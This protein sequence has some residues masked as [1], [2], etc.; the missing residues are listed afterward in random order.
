M[1]DE[2]YKK[3]SIVQQSCVDV[4]IAGDDADEDSKKM[5]RWVSKVWW[6]QSNIRSKDEVKRLCRG[7][8]DGKAATAWDQKNKRWGT[9]LIEN[10]P[11]LIASGL[12]TPDGIDPSLADTIAMRISTQL[13]R[14]SEQKTSNEKTGK[15]KMAALPQGK[16]KQ[17]QPPPPQP[18]SAETAESTK[19][20]KFDTPES[21]LA[22][23]AEINEVFEAYGMDEET[24]RQTARWAWLGSSCTRS[25]VRVRRWFNFSRNKERGVSTV[26]KEDFSAF[27]QTARDEQTKAVDDA[28]VRKAFDSNAA[29]TT[30]TTTTISDMEKYQILKSREMALIKS[31]NV[32][33]DAL[34][35]ENEHGAHALALNEI[36]SKGAATPIAKH[37]ILFKCPFCN[38]RPFEQF[39]QCACADNASANWKRC[40]VC[41]VI[42]HPKKIPCH[43]N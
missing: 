7:T 43:C 5:R 42:C 25:I 35:W 21:F 3:L 27:A 17:P 1:S 41:N 36:T 15:M 14:E 9:H 37:P 40:Y 11:N 20:A 8:V 28:R 30:T 6:G 2:L 13:R 31:N 10:V 26:L 19:R 29:T 18:P 24:F 12:W 32:A 38:T 23:D 4:F 34:K 33:A 22:S 39:M 16:R